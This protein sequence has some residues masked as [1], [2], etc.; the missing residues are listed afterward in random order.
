[1]YSHLEICVRTVLQCLL[2]TWV[3]IKDGSDDRKMGKFFWGLVL[4]AA[5]C[6]K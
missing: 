6:Q 3:R 4:K 5:G 1:M 2:K